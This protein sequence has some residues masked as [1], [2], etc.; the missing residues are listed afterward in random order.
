[1]K[2]LLSR[3]HGGS[4]GRSPNWGLIMIRQGNGAGNYTEF[5]LHDQ[6]WK[7]ILNLNCFASIQENEIVEKKVIKL[8]N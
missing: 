8:E 2:K 7:K 1:M 5:E 6:V 3:K 4:F